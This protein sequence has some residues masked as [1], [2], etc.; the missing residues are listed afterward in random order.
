[1]NSAK[2]ELKIS[3]LYVFLSL[4]AIGFF[5][6]T[7][8]E[9]DLLTN[10]EWKLVGFVDVEADN[11]KIAQPTDEWCYTFLF[12]KNKRWGG[13]SSSNSIGG[14]YKINYNTRYI[15]ISMELT[16]LNNEYSDGYLYLESLEKVDFFSLQE[17]ELKLYY[18]DKQNY[19]LYKFR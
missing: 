7:K 1:M 5:A 14:K 9:R 12:K 4:L 8:S 18:N 15:N 16:T 3:T 10:N 6:C 11:M 2:R 19:L 17:N 13:I